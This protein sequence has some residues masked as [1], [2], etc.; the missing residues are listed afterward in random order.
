M[1]TATFSTNLPLL[2]PIQNQGPPVSG[3]VGGYVAAFS[4]D[5]HSLV[6]STYLGGQ[7]GSM[8]LSSLLFNAD[9]TLRVSG[10]AAEGAIPG[11]QA[12]QYP[13]PSMGVLFSVEFAAGDPGF[14][15]AFFGGE[16]NSIVS[17]LQ[18]A[19]GTPCLVLG[20]PVVVFYPGSAA[21]SSPAQATQG[22][23]PGLGC[24]T[25]HG[26]DFQL[27]TQT[28][29][30]AVAPSQ[31]GGVWTAGPGAIPLDLL[32]ASLQPAGDIV[33]NY[34][35]LGTPPPVLA[36]PPPLLILAMS[37]FDLPNHYTTVSLT[38]RNFALGMYLSLG[39]ASLPLTINDSENATLTVTPA[40]PL[41]AG[42]YMGQ[43]VVPVQP[44]AVMSDPFPVVV[45]NEQPAPVPF[46]EISPGTFL[47]S[48]PAYLTSQVT[49]RGQSFPVM[50]SGTGLEVQ[51]PSALLQSGPGTLTLTNPPPGGGVETQNIQI[52]N[53]VV[54]GLPPAPA[55]RLQ[56]NAHAFLVDRQREILYTLNQQPSPSYTLTAYQLP[57][58]K[59]IASSLISIGSASAILDF[60]I[61]VD[62]AYLYTT[63]D[64]LNITRYETN[65][66]AK[67]FQV[68]IANDAIPG[69]SGEIS[70][71]QGVTVR[72]FADN[73]RSFVASTPGGQLIVY[74]GDQPR[75][76]TTTDFPSAVISNFDP[77]LA[78]SSYVYAITKAGTS[79]V[80]QNIVMAPCVARYPIDS[81]GF[82]PPENF[83]NLGFEWGKY[84]EMQ[85]YA[86]ILVLADASGAIPIATK[87]NNLGSL[88]L[89]QS[90]DIAKNIVA[91]P[92]DEARII[93]SDLGTGVLTGAYPPQGGVA[94]TTVLFLNDETMVFQEVTLGGLLASV[95]AHWPSAIQP[96]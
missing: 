8:F 63:D 27:I 72:V 74:D 86:G 1:H 34:I 48:A 80:T 7:G 92:Y 42:T 50:Q 62:G 75:P 83:C 46:G 67:D 69:P 39:G 25:A 20:G 44:Q 51:I 71:G 95:V 61:S 18:L 13:P 28:G 31:K 30:T 26:N 57:G 56:F 55:P 68:Q 47:V 66:F 81:L 41:E 40:S 77:V 4:A 33:L 89:P 45:M 49:W 9:S 70:A 22:Y 36:N 96:Y 91:N 21:V 43:L 85:T 59:Q 16:S 14:R 64:Q 58:G 84:P 3:G 52:S 5:L 24:L 88:R 17:A 12:V 78:S 93:L 10:S 35:D 76:Y 90:V 54:T 23:G 19:N 87:P 60:E 2:N 38:G 82:G 73:P 15:Q 65:G 32:S 94:A 79:S 6:F 53:G 37:P 11:L 29:G